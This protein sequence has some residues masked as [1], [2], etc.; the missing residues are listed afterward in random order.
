LQFVILATCIGLPTIEPTTSAGTSQSDTSRLSVKKAFANKASTSKPIRA[1]ALT[2]VSTTD[3]HEP[4]AKASTD[5]L[6]DFPKSLWEWHVA[7]GHLNYDHVLYL[8]RRP[9]SGVKLEGSKARPTCH[10]CLEA[11]I[12]RRYSRSKTSRATQPLMRIHVDIIGGGDAFSTDDNRSRA[13]PLAPNR[14]NY[15]LS[16]GI[17]SYVQGSNCDC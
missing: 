3:T 11:K 6:S 8:A 7:L 17:Q 4:R 12:T 10:V 16:M 1:S 9:S 14:Y 5:V 13:V 2:T 15:F